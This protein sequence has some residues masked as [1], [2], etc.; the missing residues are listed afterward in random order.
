MVTEATADSL[1]RGPRVS[2]MRHYLDH[3][4]TS[5]LR[6]AVAEAMVSAWTTG[7]ADPGRLHVEGMTAR[8]A[9]ET[10]RERVADFIGARPREVVFTSGGTEAIAMAAF[11][12]ASSRG[13]HTVLSGVEHSAVREWSER[14]PETLVAV[15]REGRI[16]VDGVAAAVG[17]DTGLVHCQWG[18][19]EMGTV[20]AIDEVVTA[21][22]GRALLHTDAVAAVGHVP[23]AF[24]GS[25]VDL[26][27]LS[28]HK[29]GGPPGIGALV[30]RRGLRIDPLLV[31]GDQER[32]RRAG[33]ENVAAIVGL[34]AACDELATTSGD[35]ARTTGDLSARVMAWADATDGVS[36]VGDRAARL[37]HVVCLALDGVEPQPVLLGLDQAGVAV[38]SG[39]SCSSEAIEPSP[40]LAAMGLD[41]ERSLR[42]SFGWSSTAADVDALLEAL[43]RVLDQL[44]ALRT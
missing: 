29:F 40:V 21:V 26:L 28:A 24:G 22:D 33:M 36:V 14:G 34:A 12:A 35:E 41:A 5:P 32:A 20:Q 19:H 3:A 6:P 16:D 7:G 38:H 8:V 43:P 1:A 2:S 27:S 17:P 42:I 44:R 11:G 4:S 37:P 30:V 25:G 18:N 13:R 31:G 23:V 39:S 10:A 9:V 15:D